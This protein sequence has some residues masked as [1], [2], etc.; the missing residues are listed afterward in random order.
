MTEKP[1][2]SYIYL[3]TML[4]VIVVLLCGILVTLVIGLIRTDRPSGPVP[5]IVHSRRQAQEARRPLPRKHSV[6]IPES[7][8][9]ST[10][11]SWEDAAKHYGEYLTVEGTIVLTYNSGKACFLNFHSDWKKHFTVVIFASDFSKF[12]SPPEEYYRGKKIQVTGRIKSYHG[13]PEI[14]VEDP[15]Q[16]ELLR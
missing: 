13:K 5:G 12:P 4:G 2:I 14:I 9:E 6:T 11:I 1:R 10:V 8:E 7:G 16:I 3:K 15:S